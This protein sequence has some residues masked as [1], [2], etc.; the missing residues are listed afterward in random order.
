MSTKCNYVIPRQ[1]LSRDF[2][3]LLDLIQAVFLESDNR[4]GIW[5]HL[6]VLKPFDISTLKAETLLS[7]GV[8]TEHTWCAQHAYFETCPQQG[9]RMQPWSDPLLTLV[10]LGHPHTLKPA[11]K[12]L[13]LLTNLRLCISIC[14][15]AQMKFGAQ[16]LSQCT[17]K[18]QPWSK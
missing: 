15:H 5:V 12:C 14:A 16:C 1:A 2:P 17:P 4:S 9:P 7:E 6:Q 18:I 11:Y 10:P 3:P 8:P 13:G